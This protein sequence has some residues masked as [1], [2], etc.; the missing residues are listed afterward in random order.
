M[1]SGEIKFWHSLV[2]K[3]GLFFIGLILLAIFTSGYLI[4]QRASNIIGAFSKERISHSSL[5]AEQSFYS[6]LAEVENDI[7]VMSENAKLQEY[8]HTPNPDLKNEIEHLFY[9]TLKNKPNY[10][11][12]RLIS[13]NDFGQ[14][15]IR[16]DKKGKEVL[17][18]STDLLQNKSGRPYF[19]EALQLNPEEFYFS[20]IS[21]NEEFG[22][23]SPSL[24]PTI[25]AVSLIYDKDQKPTNMLVINL[26]LSKFY[27]GLRNIMTSGIELMLVDHSGQ[28]LFASNMTKCFSKQLK[29]YEKFDVDFT[30]PFSDIK[31]D[32]IRFESL[33]SKK[34]TLLLSQIKS[35]FY[36]QNKHQIFILA[37]MKESIALRSV[38]YIKQYSYQII[39]IVSLAAL[40]IAMIFIRILALRIGSITQAM[41]DYE[42][43]S[44]PVIKVS[45]NRKDELGVL[46]RTFI[47]MKARIIQQV[48]DLRS[49]LDK[50]QK[51]VVEKDQFLQNMSHELRTPLNAILGL[52]QLIKKNNPTPEQEPIVNAIHRSAQSLAGLMYDI[53]DH[54]KLIEGQVQL[55]F[56]PANISELLS[57]IHSS[58]RFEAINKGLGF[59]LNIDP[60]LQGIYHQTDAL[61]FTQIISNLIVNAIKFTDAGKVILEATVDADE[62][63]T[64]NIID[65]GRGILSEN[66]EKIRERFYQEKHNSSSSD[67]FGLGLSIVKQLIDLFSGELIIKS[68]IGVGSTFTVKLPLQVTDY[69]TNKNSDSMQRLSFDDLEENKTILHL[70][71]DE[72]ARLLIHQLIQSP[73]IELIQTNNW[74]F[75]KQCIEKQNPDLI[76]SDLMIEN[77]DMSEML[78]TISK[79]PSIPIIVVSALEEIQMQKI[80]NYYLQKPFD[81]E[82]FLDLCF[83][84]LNK[85]KCD[86]PK[87]SNSYE[88]YD[89]DKVKIEKFMTLLISE[90]ETYIERIDQAFENQDESEWI[91]IRHKLITHIRSLE[92]NNLNEQLPVQLADLSNQKLSVIK[93]LLSYNLSYFRNESRLLQ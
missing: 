49:A 18:T 8:A 31:T 53:L 29:S 22:V 34:G 88:Q 19:K 57:D 64:I 73:K 72:S 56:K 42:Q 91:A 27:Q 71:D 39:P 60:S 55:K 6:L 24:T 43:E 81:I 82:Q 93:K 40:I 15:I 54:H 44:P 90:F 65:T 62:S 67:G 75:A 23:V 84:I 61:R 4:Y 26:D 16:L 38:Y 70:E 25:R 46:A 17:S 35:L 9:V 21:L 28:Y 41:G 20:H 86:Q 7:S 76:I 68:E 33:K 52:T 5:L 63:L 3:F 11:Q 92:L 77:F 36:S 66:L 58:Y 69:R 51:A 1:E 78:T 30:V 85:D 10:F 87:L 59:E 45:E 14:E 50:E 13:L 48:E 12:I 79:K 32:S 74:A 2:T 47:K 89:H 37:Y 83:I 80:S